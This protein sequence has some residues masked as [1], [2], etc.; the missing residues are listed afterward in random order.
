MTDT[1][2]DGSGSA[3]GSGSDPPADSVVADPPSADGGGG[4]LKG[5]RAGAHRL[6]PPATTLERMARFLPAIGITRVA[7]VTGLDRVGVPVVMAIR[8][9][10]RSLA[11]CQG[12]GPSR[13]AARAS[14]VMEAVEHYHAERVQAPLRLASWDE[15]RHERPTVDPSRLPRLEGGRFH[16]GH[17]LLWIEADVLAAQRHGP[18]DRAWLP[19]ELVHLDHTLPLPAGSGCFQ[20]TSNGLASG[21]H[22]AEAT[23]HALCELIERDARSLALATSYE[24][25]G[26]DSASVDDPLCRDVLARFDAAGLQVGLWELTSDVGVAVFECRIVD[27]DDNPMRRTVAAG[28]S[29]CHPSR[30]VAL[31]RAL[32]EAA[33]S[34]LTVIA[35][36]RDDLG[37]A[38]YERLRNPATLERERR[39]LRA[40]TPE[41]AFH[42]AP[43][44]A[45]A[46]FEADLELLAARLAVVGCDQILRIDLTQPW[47][48]EVAAVVRVVVPG[49]EGMAELEGAAH[50]ARLRAAVATVRD[51]TVRDA[52]V[53]DTVVRDGTARDA[54]VRDDSETP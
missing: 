6:V 2:P 28:G 27:R 46:T 36:A 10:A 8:P 12:K 51:D 15:M 45:G 40:A 48:R 42:D 1:P 44:L 30:S 24:G 18:A 43:E 17:R 14:G 37:R 34:R 25:R 31:L 49:L 50:G 38:D 39:R 20:M 29:G 5:H 33:Q 52:T 9:N 19:Y 23:V 22:L 26:V 3:G 16:A 35:G 13:D 11:V 41:R 53:R 7:D 4:T 21:N 32:T 47:L 54:T